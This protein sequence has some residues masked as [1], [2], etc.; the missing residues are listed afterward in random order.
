[1]LVSILSRLLAGGL[2]Q[3]MDFGESTVLGAGHVEQRSNGR[4]WTQGVCRG[5][6][7]YREMRSER[8][9]SVYETAESEYLQQRGEER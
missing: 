5:Q 3:D 2:S 1:M 9:V 7:S 6:S 4:C 8:V